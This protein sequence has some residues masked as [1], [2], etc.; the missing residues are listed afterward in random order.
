[1]ATIEVRDSNGDEVAVQLPNAN[2]RAA[3]AASR[4]VVL[5][6]ED[7]ALF[8]VSSVARLLSAAASTN[9]TLV[10]SGAGNTRS[11]IGFSKRATDCW[12]KLYNKAT[13]PTVGTDTPVA[14]I[15]IPAGSAFELNLGGLAFALG[16]GYALTTAAADADTG[17]LTAGDVV[18]F[19]LFYT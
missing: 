2:G 3:A 5:S 1:M 19:N 13:A 12:L 4:P 14:T 17:A 7:A 9:A 18:G 8:A 11:V 6:T 16:I 10:K 15:P